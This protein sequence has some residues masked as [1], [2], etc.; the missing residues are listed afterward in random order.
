MY[1]VELPTPSKRV[2]RAYLATPS[3]KGRVTLRLTLVDSGPEFSNGPY[4]RAEW[5]D[6]HW[7][8][9]KVQPTK[10]TFLCAFGLTYHAA[11]NNALEGYGY[12]IT[13]E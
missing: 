1:S 4:I 3:G 10:W 2:T 13:I 11:L 5:V 8:D 7:H 12:R 6:G 9:R